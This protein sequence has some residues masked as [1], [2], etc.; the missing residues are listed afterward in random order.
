MK[1]P[2]RNTHGYHEF[3][4][5]DGNGHTVAHFLYASDLLRDTRREQ[6]EHIVK[7]VNAYPR[8]VDELKRVS[9]ILGARWQLPG[10]VSERQVYEPIDKLLR[11]LG[12]RP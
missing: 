2:L 11:E 4:L 3:V 7:A 8:L 10:E 1:L 9:D 6:V 5:I 12:E